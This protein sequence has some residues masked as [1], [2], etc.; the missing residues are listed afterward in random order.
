VDLEQ[1]LIADAK[2]LD[3]QVK[4]ID[5]DT[6]LTEVFAALDD[7]G[8]DPHSAS[9]ATAAGPVDTSVGR[10]PAP[11]AR[12]Q[13]DAGTDQGWAL[14]E[15]AYFERQAAE[16]GDGWSCRRAAELSEVLG[17]REEASEW[18]R[19]AAAAGD[20]DAQDYVNESLSN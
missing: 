4:A 3:R 7:L 13:D 9:A 12:R 14:R 11:P 2:A 5:V 17:R 19:R 8:H 18:W 15:L 6:Y 1:R 10:A 20:E 16:K